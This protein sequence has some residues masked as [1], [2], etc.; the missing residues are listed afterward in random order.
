MSQ[1]FIGPQ[2]KMFNEHSYKIFVLKM[3]SVCL[4]NVND[5]DVRSSVRHFSKSLNNI[6]YDINGCETSG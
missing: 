5:T 6:F 2:A 3:V 4:G 1:C